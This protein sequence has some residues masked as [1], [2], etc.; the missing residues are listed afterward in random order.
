MD[1]S[2]EEINNRQKNIVNISPTAIAMIVGIGG[3][4]SWVAMDLALIGVKTIILVDPDKIELTNLNRTL[5]KLDHVNQFKTVALKEL[6][7]E[8]RADVLVIN[9]EERFEESTLEKYNQIDYIFDCTDNSR[10]KDIFGD[11]KLKINSYLKLGYDGFEG[12][13][14]LNNYKSGSWGHESGYTVIPSFFGTPQIISAIAV[15]E[16]LM[17][18]S[19]FSETIN[20]DVREM[21]KKFRVDK[22]ELVKQELAKTKGKDGKKK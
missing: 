4:G 16:V 5:F 22:K 7:L 8:R 1:L 20:F 3:I 17:L 15:I 2:F 10:T 9:H 21:L 13:F 6:I 11:S 12:T 18:K 14:D 19:N